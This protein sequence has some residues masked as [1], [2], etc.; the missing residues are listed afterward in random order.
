MGL[1]RGLSSDQC[2]LVIRSKILDLKEGSES[3]RESGDAGKGVGE[4]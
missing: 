4:V 1:S 2:C 3:G